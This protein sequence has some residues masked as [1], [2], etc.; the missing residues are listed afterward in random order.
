M[1]ELRVN[2]DNDVLV[3]YEGRSMGMLIS[4]D[5]NRPK[6]QVTVNYREL[7]KKDKELVDEYISYLN[8]TY[9]R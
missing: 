2:K 5:T 4:D 6:L 8:M 7:E 3:M 9:H 1:L